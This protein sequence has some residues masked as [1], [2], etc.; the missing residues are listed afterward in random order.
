MSERRP[1]GDDLPAPRP[2]F[3]ARLERAEAWIDGKPIF[4][5]VDPH[6]HEPVNHT[7]VK[8]IQVFFRKESPEQRS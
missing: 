3:R 8:E 4:S 5:R 1:R 7:Q 6:E 2:N